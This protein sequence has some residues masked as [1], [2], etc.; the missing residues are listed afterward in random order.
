MLTIGSLFS[1]IG[2]LELGLEWAGLGPTFWQVE[3]DAKRRDVLARHWPEA[4]QH[5][6]VCTVE[7]T[8]LAPVDLICGGFPCQDVSSAGRRAGLAGARSGLWYEFAR[9]AAERRPQWVVVENVGSGARKW[10]DAVC[11]D[12]GRLGYASLPVPIAASDSRSSPRTST[13]FPRRGYCRL[14]WRPTRPGVR[15]LGRTV[16]RAP[17]AAPSCPCRLRR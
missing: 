12:L 8:T 1:G 17:C 9:I 16:S 6:D 13:C 15:R 7:A 10:V 5:E 3:K 11:R 2:G 14:R 4:E